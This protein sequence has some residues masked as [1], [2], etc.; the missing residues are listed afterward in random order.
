MSDSGS[1][2]DPH[3]LQLGE[4]IWVPMTEAEHRRRSRLS[5][6]C[7]AGPPHT[8]RSG[9]D[10]GHLASDHLPG[11]IRKW[12]RWRSPLGVGAIPPLGYLVSYNVAVI[13]LRCGMSAT[14]LQPKR[15][16]AHSRLP[17]ALRT[18]MP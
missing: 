15:S 10:K 6:H 4:P 17:I 11:D 14:T 13:I 12:L 18:T 7:W 9:K 3:P 16:T 5:E 8:P 1:G 2:N